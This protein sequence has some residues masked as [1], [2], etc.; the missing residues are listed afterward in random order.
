[1][2]IIILRLSTQTGLNC[3]YNGHDQWPF[4][5]S[6]HAGVS[7]FR[8]VK[9]IRHTCSSGIDSYDHSQIWET[10]SGGYK[11]PLQTRLPLYLGHLH[12]GNI[13]V[14]SPKQCKLGGYENMLLG[15][16]TKL[17]RKCQEEDYLQYMDIIM[18]G[19]YIINVCVCWNKEVV[20][21]YVSCSC[22][23]SCTD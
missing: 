4:A 3:L 21:E 20:T 23:S 19:E 11:L 22:K 2:T 16:R 7:T 10:D 1:M 5:W 8:L 18:F 13:F 6:L 9:E 14:L 15:Y 17:Y 12:T